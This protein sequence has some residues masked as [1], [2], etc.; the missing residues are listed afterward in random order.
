MGIGVKSVLRNWAV[1]RERTELEMWK[2]GRKG[3]CSFVIFCFSL[4]RDW[5][6]SLFL[7]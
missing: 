6:V 7:R 1:R 3:F 5:N 4:R 2:D